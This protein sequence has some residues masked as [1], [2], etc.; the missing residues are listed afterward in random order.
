MQVLRKCTITTVSGTG[1]LI[2]ENVVAGTY[3]VT[4]ADER[5]DGFALTGLTCNDSDSTTDLTTRR[6]TIQLSAG[7][8]VVCTYSSVNARGAAQTAIR[9]ALTTRNTLILSNQ[10]KLQRRLDRLKG[11][12]AG[13]SINAG[14][15]TLPG[16]NKLPVQ[17]NISDRN[18]SFAASLDSARH[19]GG[20]PNAGQKGSLDVW[21]EGALNSFTSAGR[22]GDFSVIYAGV[23]YLVSDN[24][25]IGGLVQYDQFDQD[26]DLNDV[27][28]LESDGFMVGPY[29]TTRVSDNVY[30][31]ARAAW[32]TSSNKVA[33]IAGQLDEFDTERAL[34]S[35]TV[36]GEFELGSSAATL[37]RPEISVHYISETQQQYTDLLGVDISEQT[38]DQGEVSFAPRIQHSVALENGW[39]ARPYGQVRGIY[40]FG[41][42]V[43]L[44]GSDSRARFEGGVDLFSGGSLTI[45]VSAFAD[46]IGA[47]NFSSEGGRISVSIT[48]R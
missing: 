2:A 40:S 34:L 3:V 41:D 18:A 5:A 15:L 30:L 48:P 47:D 42:N 8:N 19:L 6:A 22:D 45:G 43:E 10:P 24:V 29:V 7:E 25:L 27:G 46:G 16:S 26:N 36:T 13:G 33:S 9:Q 12:S 20:S 35:G 32:G 39:I 28:G 21:V 14:G 23:D 31:D 4:A 37:L 38:I 17:A 1:S 44:L 11:N